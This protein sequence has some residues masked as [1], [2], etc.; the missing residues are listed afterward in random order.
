M[1]IT[2]E[3]LLILRTA[4]NFPKAVYIILIQSGG[5]N[6]VYWFFFRILEHFYKIILVM[7]I[8]RLRKINGVDV[9]N[10]E[11]QKK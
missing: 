1:L 6:I 3:E 10:L 11:A 4:I 5:S 7:H 9:F 2:L 8:I